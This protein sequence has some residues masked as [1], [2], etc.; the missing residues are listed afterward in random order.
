MRT[1]WHVNHI[2]NPRTSAASCADLVQKVSSAANTILQA[3]Q[4]D[5][6]KRFR[7]DSA[8]A[9]W[10]EWLELQKRA[11]VKSA[12]DETVAIASPSTSDSFMSQASKTSSPCDSSVS[13]LEWRMD[14]FLLSPEHYQRYTLTQFMYF[15][16]L[17]C[18]SSTAVCVYL[19]TYIHTFYL[20]QKAQRCKKN[21]KHLV[22]WTERSREH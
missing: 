17:D 13:T 3:Y 8:P 22:S 15:I 4:T 5:M 9:Q 20:A 14:A 12:V 6:K 2:R 10:K 1:F 21:S 18:R 16:L 7:N 11:P 19:H